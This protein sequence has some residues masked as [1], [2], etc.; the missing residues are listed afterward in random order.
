MVLCEITRSGEPEYIVPD[1]RGIPVIFRKAVVGSQPTQHH[2]S[3]VQP[4]L[5]NGGCCSSAGGCVKWLAYLCLID[6]GLIHRLLHRGHGTVG[7]TCIGAV[8][9]ELSSRW[10][11][12]VRPLFVIRVPL[13]ILSF[14]SYN[15][16]DTSPLLTTL[17]TVFFWWHVGPSKLW[18]GFLGG[19]RPVTNDSQ[20]R[21]CLSFQMDTTFET[22][23]GSS[24]SFCALIPK[25]AELCLYF[26]SSTENL[27]PTSI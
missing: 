27:S 11:S 15:A 18:C 22:L 24:L 20:D 7:I 9:R 12:K 14:P 3:T 16:A 23:C 25:P 13:F 19:W 8:L 26:S 2:R 6:A 21:G 4:L 10:A 5:R 1:L 17:S